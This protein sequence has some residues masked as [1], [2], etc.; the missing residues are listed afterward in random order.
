MNKYRIPTDAWRQSATVLMRYPQTKRDL[1]GAIDEAITRN[2]ERDGGGSKPS[3]PDPTAT[4]GIR[5]YSNQRYQRMR[6]E[7][8]AVEDAIKGLDSV[9]MD[10][11]RQRYWK[12]KR[13]TSYE[14][15][16]APYSVRQMQRIVQRVMYRIAVNL[17]EI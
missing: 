7:V 1:Q 5:L 16:D 4:S 6:R 17:G 3:H 15:I 10:V 13:K 2:P 11:I 9:E 8:K 12:H 14:R